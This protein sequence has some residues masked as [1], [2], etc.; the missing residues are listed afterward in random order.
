LK[1]EIQRISKLVSEGKLSP[2]D[3]ADLIDA[4]YRSEERE[5]APQESQA[6]ARTQPGPG[7]GALNEN[8]FHSLIDAI[9][10]IGKEASESVN[11]KEVASTAKSS[12]AKGLELLKSGIDDISKGKVNIGWLLTQ[13]T[14]E[15][16]L[17]LAVTEGK[18]LKIENGTGAIRIHHDANRNEVVALAKFRSNTLE[19]SKLKAD[20]YTLMVETS[21]HGIT[22]KQPSVSGTE[23]DLDIYVSVP[24]PVDIRS[25]TGYVQVKDTRSSA[26]IYSKTGAIDISGLNGTIELTSETGSISVVQTESPSVIIENKSGPVRLSEV[27]GNVN[28]RSATG[29]IELHRC[30]GRSMAIE[31]VTGMVAVDLDEPVTGTVSIRTVNGSASVRIPD[32]SDCRVS[33]T[34]LRGTATS[35]IELSDEA[36]SE[37][38]IT[39]KLGSGSGTL[40]VSA[41]TG[42][43]SLSLRDSQ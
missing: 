6:E 1:E 18:T 41:V 15:I 42:T 16:R 4:F 32:G 43:V 35:Y 8:P 30:S 40:D 29:T 23:V 36:K 28:L 34:T 25:E 7:T 3:A 39:G 33:L 12:A 21:D 22:I 27:R 13:A 17:P 20:A 5:S 10:K 38:R 2:E 26:R 37:Q 24:I 14:R 19:E 11:W 31:A 9:E